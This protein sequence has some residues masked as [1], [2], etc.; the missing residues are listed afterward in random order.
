MLADRPEVAHAFDESGIDAYRLR[1]VL[2]AAQAWSES[3]RVGSEAASALTELAERVE[4]SRDGIRTSLKVPVSAVEAP[5][6]L[7]SSHIT[8]AQ[9]IP[10]QMKRRGVEMR[11]V[12]EGTSRTGRIDLPLLKAAR[13]PRPQMVGRLNRGAGTFS[14]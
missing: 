8:L 5:D 13:G 11:L 1:S 10:M 9:F 6:G 7:P 14:R 2:K 3:L 4:L 12:L